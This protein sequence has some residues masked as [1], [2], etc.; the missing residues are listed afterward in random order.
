MAEAEKKK[1]KMEPSGAVGGKR[2][3]SK[4][5]SSAGALEKKN[6]RTKVG[7]H[8]LR[9]IPASS[10]LSSRHHRRHHLFAARGDLRIKWRN[11]VETVRQRREAPLLQL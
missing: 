1:A 11:Q 8:L 5:G 3:K 10:I 7:E 4:G 2:K 9:S 6:A